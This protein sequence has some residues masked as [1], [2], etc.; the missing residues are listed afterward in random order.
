[1]PAP[2]YVAGANIAGGDILRIREAL[3]ETLEDSSLRSTKEMLLLDGV[4]E[5]SLDAYRPIAELERDALAMGCAEFPPHSLMVL[6]GDLGKWGN[7]QKTGAL[8]F[9]HAP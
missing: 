1:M 8:R 7:I 2:P 9:R 3:V 6:S 5:V 4:E